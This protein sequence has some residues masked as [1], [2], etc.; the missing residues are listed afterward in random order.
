M[1]EPIK[2]MPISEFRELGFLQEVNRLVLHPAGLALEITVDDFG[3]EY[4]SGVWDY[5]DD[6]EGIV[7][8]PGQMTEEKR[9]SVRVEMQKHFRAR[10]EMLGSAA[11]TMESYPGRVQHLDELSDA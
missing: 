7:Y 1:S 5:R 8:G 4:I 10:S 9:Q 6:P 11:P 2:Y 3:N